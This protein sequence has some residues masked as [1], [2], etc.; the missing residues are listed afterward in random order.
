[1]TDQAIA[2]FNAGS[3][4]L[5]FALYRLAGGAQ[6]RCINHGQIA[7][8]GHIGQQSRFVVYDAAGVVL[9]DEVCDVAD[10]AAALQRLLQWLDEHQH[11]LELLAVGHRVVH[12]G[13]AFAAP[14]VVD[15]AVLEQLKQLIPLAPLHQPHNLKAIEALRT[16][17]PD[18]PQVACFDT[19][20]HRTMPA[21]AQRY[22]LPHKFFE[23][24]VRAYGFHGLSY[25]YIASL[26]PGY[27]GD[28]A[29][30]RVIVAHLGNGASMCAMH[31]GKSV[32]TTMGFTPLDGLVM[33]TRCGAIDPGVLLYLLRQGMSVDELDDL[34]QQ[35]SGLLGL[36]GISSDMRALLASSDKHAV[37]AVAQF[38]YR[39]AREI[40]SLA[41]ALAGLDA[42]VFTGGIGEHSVAIRESICQ[43]SQWL[44]V[45]LDEVANRNNSACISTAESA[46]SVWVMATDEEL[47]IARH[48]HKLVTAS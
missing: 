43:Q 5:K 26:L 40:G 9:L 22:A 10:H 23:S 38:C 4:S 17:R 46:V 28:V 33:G 16:F 7:G 41:A 29:G 31:G 25:E 30:G 2:V 12:G 21:V 20:F 42:I 44:G 14:V 34:L 18:L 39:A 36:S 8:I 37:E 48:C 47:V 11:G 19:A 24:G 1:M 27:L 3:S 35:R 15:D 6:L 32:A 13:V 45:Q